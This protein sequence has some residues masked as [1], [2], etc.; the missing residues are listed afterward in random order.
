MSMLLARHASIWHEMHKITDFDLTEVGYLAFK[1][2]LQQN[3]FS[4]S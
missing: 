1:I 2:I 4:F 3:I